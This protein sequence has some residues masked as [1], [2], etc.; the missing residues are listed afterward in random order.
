MHWTKSGAILDQ[1]IIGHY[2][3]YFMGDAAGDNGA[4][5]MGVAYSDDLLHWTEPLDHPILEHRAG[6]FDSKVVEPGPAPV[7]TDKG[8]LLI[9]NG[10][11]GTVYRTGWVLF[12]K[13]D[14]TKVLARAEAPVFEP[15]REW[16]KVG[17]VPNVVFVEGMIR[18]SAR[19]LL[20]YGA[21]DKYVGVAST[22][23]EN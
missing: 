1:K 21:A 19:W 3:M 8:I 12:D 5:Q 20:Y 15:K 6:R 22:R 9:Y 17:Q 14:P 7:L 11:D 2:W 18:D 4:N 13:T 10:G 23:L 16:E